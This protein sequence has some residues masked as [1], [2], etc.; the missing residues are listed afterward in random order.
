VFKHRR[1][2]P[3]CLTGQ[4]NA[5]MTNALSRHWPEYVIEAAGLGL[6]HVRLGRLPVLCAKLDHG[7]GRRCIFRCGYAS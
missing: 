5:P 6:F 1:R 3:A 7:G 2:G 4:G